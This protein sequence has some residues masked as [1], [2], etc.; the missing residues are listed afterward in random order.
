MSA[1][2]CGR[3]RVIFAGGISKAL[4]R[5]F[6]ARWWDPRDPGETAAEALIRANREDPGICSAHLVWLTTLASL[7][8]VAEAERRALLPGTVLVR[9]LEVADD[10]TFEPL[11]PA[12]VK[13]A[14]ARMIEDARW[15]IV[16]AARKFVSHSALAAVVE[17]D[18]ASGRGRLTMHVA[19]SEPLRDTII[20]S[21]RLD[22]TSAQAVV[23]GLRPRA[24]G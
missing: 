16:A 24:V 8:I 18:V 9:Y 19:G 3:R 22:R 20:D 21:K 4:E 7:A 6:G 17:L 23:E 13:L 1:C 5:W 11:T 12:E 10:R 14:A 2:A 15:G